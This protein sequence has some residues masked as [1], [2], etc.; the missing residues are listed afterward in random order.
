VY[1]GMTST[2]RAEDRRSRMLDAAL[3]LMG[4]PELGPP[5]VRKVL[6]RSGV[7][8]RYFYDHF[9]DL[10]ELQLAVFAMLAAEAE[11]VG[12]AAMLAAP[13]RTAAR[14]R[15]GLAALADL[16]LDDPRKGRVLVV[17]PLRSPVLGPAYATQLR[18]FASLLANYSPAVWRGENPESRAVLVTTQF[19]L[20]GFAATMTAVL[21]GE[22]PD[23]RKRL[24]DE[25]TALFLGVGSTFRRLSP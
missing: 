7:A 10:D 24:V 15:A 25:L 6:S 21:T 22:L 3:D 2:E 9:T 5:T 1:G 16:L 18:R 12:T 4:S 14:T 23:D 13:R 20:G 11:Q 19:A 17:E 8:P